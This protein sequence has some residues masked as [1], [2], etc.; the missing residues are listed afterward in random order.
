[1]K[2]VRRKWDHRKHHL[3][4]STVFYN[5]ESYHTS[6]FFSRS[7]PHIHIYIHY[8]DCNLRLDRCIMRISFNIQLNEIYILLRSTWEAHDT[9]I[10]VCVHVCHTND[11]SPWVSCAISIENKRYLDDILHLVAA[12]PARRRYDSKLPI[13]IYIYIDIPKISGCVVA[14]S[15]SRPPSIMRHNNDK[16]LPRSKFAS[17]EAAASHRAGNGWITRIHAEY[18]IARPQLWTMASIH[19]C[20]T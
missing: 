8:L 11:F 3:L 13:Y 19:L 6:E 16:I 4:Q 14:G 2:G 12:C 1:M 15:P 10:C 17:V 5:V 7:Y 20:E 9:Y 18:S